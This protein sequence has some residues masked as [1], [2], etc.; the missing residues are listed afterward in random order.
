[1]T[2][3]VFELLSWGFCGGGLC[4]GFDFGVDFRSG[5]RIDLHGGQD[6]LEAMKDFVAV[7]CLVVDFV[8]PVRVGFGGCD[9]QGEFVAGSVLE[10]VIV[11][12]GLFARAGGRFARGG[13]FRVDWSSMS[14]IINLIS[15]SAES[16]A[17]PWLGPGI[18]RGRGVWLR[19]GEFA[20]LIGSESFVHADVEEGRSQVRVGIGGVGKGRRLRARLRRAA[21]SPWEWDR[22]RRV[23]WRH[24]RS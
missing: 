23:R 16:P 13:W 9:F 1:M 22:R 12:R 18:G 2:G 21:R 10:D 14:P 15:K 20:A 4:I 5:E 17:A 11:L 7:D 3:A 24:R 8:V 19:D 6:F